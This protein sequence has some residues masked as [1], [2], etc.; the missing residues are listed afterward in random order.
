MNDKNQT[1]SD[2]SKTKSNARFF[3]ASGNP[4]ETL[5]A[6]DT[7]PQATT[8]QA[9]L[10]VHNGAATFVIQVDFTPN[11]YPFSIT[12]GTITSGICG[13]PWTVTGGV[14]GSDLRLSA[15]RTGSGTCADTLIV[16]GEYQNPPSW[17]GTYGF[18]GAA[19]SFRHT[20]LFRGFG[21]CR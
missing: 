8:L 6:G 19:S 4:A 14:M 21:A 2:S 5:D 9:C 10:E 11:T 7:T 13:A 20:T 16:V 15:K 17:R 18:N 3:D 1:P 12:G